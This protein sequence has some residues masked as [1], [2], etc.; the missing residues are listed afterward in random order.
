MGGVL[1]LLPLCLGGLREK[2]ISAGN[3]WR[4]FVFFTAI[5][6]AFLF[7]EIAF[8]QKFILFLSHPVYAVSVVLCAFLVFAGLGSGFSRRF[9]EER[10]ALVWAVGAVGLGY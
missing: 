2:S 4:T 7:L 1:I 3:R 6:L 5:G 10:M 9:D 8:I